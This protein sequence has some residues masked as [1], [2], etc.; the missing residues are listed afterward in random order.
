MGGVQRIVPRLI[1]GGGS[2]KLAGIFWDGEGG[3]GIKKFHFMLKYND[4]FVAKNLSG[5]VIT[6][7]GDRPLEGRPW[8]FKIPQE[9][10]SAWQ[11]IKLL[12]NPIEI[13]IHFSQEENCHAIWDTTGRTN[14]TTMKLPRLAVLPYAVVEW[15]SKMG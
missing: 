15:L 13:K 7:M 4:L 3:R 10:P 8:V 12:S 9:K 5:N 6:F 14:L 11:E 1:T 2:G